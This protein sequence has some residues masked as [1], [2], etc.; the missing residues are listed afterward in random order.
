MVECE[1]LKKC[2]FVNGQM[3]TDPAAAELTKKTYC[4]GDNSKCA[5]YQLVTTGFRVPVD[6][7]PDDYERAQR[8]REEEG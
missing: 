3:D 6:L 4:H 1:K 8:L 2:Q 7:R 5:R